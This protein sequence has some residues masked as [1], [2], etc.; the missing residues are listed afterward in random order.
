MLKLAQS[1]LNQLVSIIRLEVVKNDGKCSS[2]E[3]ELK[4]AFITQRASELAREVAVIATFFMCCLIKKDLA[5]WAM[6]ASIKVCLLL[7]SDFHLLSCVTVLSLL[8]LYYTFKVVK[9]MDDAAF[10]TPVLDARVVLVLRLQVWMPHRVR[11]NGS[12][13]MCVTWMYDSMSA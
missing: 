5:V 4:I 11:C 9:K 10:S 7:R 2:S 3:W 13:K 8:F 1:M 6:C 12:G